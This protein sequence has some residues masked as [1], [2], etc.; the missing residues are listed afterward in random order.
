NYISKNT[1][2]KTDLIINAIEVAS[3]ISNKQA[4]FSISIQ[5]GYLYLMGIKLIK[6]PNLKKYLYTIPALPK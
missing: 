5:N 1:S 2:A 6:F 3:E 4:V